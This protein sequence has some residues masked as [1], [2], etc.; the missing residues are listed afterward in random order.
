MKVVDLFSG[1]GGFSQAFI[2]RGH[3]V[4]R[5]DFNE[6]FKDIPYTTIKDVMELT[7]VDLE[8]AD[9]ILAS[10]PCTHFS[11]AAV[12][13]H[14]PKPLK[15][16]TKETL[17]QINLVKYTVALL[18]EVDPTY[19]MVENPQGMM[20]KI[21]GQQ[22]M[23]QCWGS[24]G[25]NALKPT[26]LWGKFPPVDWR[27]CSTSRHDKTPRGS[28][29]GVQGINISSFKKNKFA[30]NIPRDS[31]LRALIPYDFSLAVCLA[32]EGNSQQETLE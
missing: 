4:E 27:A 28:K 25:M 8:Y 17:Q 18:K 3:E 29:K 1:L 16:P 14:W 21:L 10:P 11:V 32:A 7:P 15:E 13:H 26:H 9:I 20:K 30:Y 5:Y 22:A 12:Y 23:K 19:W 24:W 2:D 31:A 6:D